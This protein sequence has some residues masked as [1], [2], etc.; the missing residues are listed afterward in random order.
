MKKIKFLLCA[1][2]CAAM[3]PGLLP[4]AKAAEARPDHSEF[5]NH[6][7][8]VNRQTYLTGEKSFRVSSNRGSSSLPPKYSLKEEGLLP[9]VRNQGGYGIC[10]AYATIAAAESNVIKKGIGGTNVDLSEMQFLYYAYGAPVDPLGNYT[11]DRCYRAD[12]S[13]LDGGNAIYANHMLAR[14]TG[15]TDEAVMTYDDGEYLQTAKYADEFVSD[16][17]E[18]HMQGYRAVNVKTD[19]ESAKRCILEYGALST[20]YMT[21]DDYYSSDDKSYYSD[22][23]TSTNHAIVIAGW[24]DDY[25][26]ENFD[27]KA[28]PENDGAWL[29]R[30]SWGAGKHDGGYFWMSYEESSLDPVCFA[31]DMGTSDDYDYC[32][33]YDGGADDKS[34]KARGMVNVFTAKTDET[35][36]AV[37]AE[38]PMDENVSYTAEIY[39]DPGAD[40]ITNET[41]AAVQTGTTTYAGMYTIPLD[42]PVSLKAGQRFAAAIT[43]ERADGENANIAYDR[44]YKDNGDWF[45]SDVVYAPCEGYYISNSSGKNVLKSMVYDN[46]TPRGTPRIKA[47]TDT[48]GIGAPEAFE[49]SLSGNVVTLT[50]N[51]AENADGYEIWSGTENGDYT[52]LDKTEDT[53]YTYT[54]S[55][56]NGLLLK[57]KVRAVSGD[58]TGIFSRSDA[59]RFETDTFAV[60]VEAENMSI[61]A[62][63]TAAPILTFDP[64]DANDK[65]VAFSADKDGIIEINPDGTFTA[66]TEGSVTVTGTPRCGGMPFDFTV[67]VT[68]R[69]E[70]DVRSGDAARDLLRWL[71][72]LFRLIAGFFKNMLPEST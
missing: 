53:S 15:L 38:F 1:V 29:I 11:G 35:L 71:R 14:W 62:G 39:L 34:M 20:A 13:L 31:Y 26:K 16:F 18:Y 59:V 70:K 17:D 25:P 57:Y 51:A 36:R 54:A 24:D 43:A 32:Y 19:P 41:P 63:K 47:Y 30:N 9:P 64:E 28:Q 66:L 3:L 60:I 67:T 37:S 49:A 45:V 56:E 61:E 55:D 65:A 69:E 5:V 52:L 21:D 8:P 33:Q 72:E 46:G 12:G 2:L 23:Y 4:A 10:W 68:P 40:F 44:A 22:R 6:Y 58:E 27:G 48:A 42:I 50:W 7:M